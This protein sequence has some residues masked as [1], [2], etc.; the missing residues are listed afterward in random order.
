MG[1]PAELNDR[2]QGL[3]SLRSTL[4][5]L[6]LQGV[7]SDASVHGRIPADVAERLDHLASLRAQLS[8]L[9]AATAQQHPQAMPRIGRGSHVSR[10]VR[11]A[12]VEM[13]QDLRDLSRS[14]DARRTSMEGMRAQIAAL[15]ASEVD[16]DELAEQLAAAASAARHQ[17]RNGRMTNEAIAATDLALADV[18]RRG[19]V[20]G[21]T[22]YG[23]LLPQRRGDGPSGGERCLQLVR[24]QHT[25]AARP[26]ALANSSSAD[27]ERELAAARERMRRRGVLGGSDN[28]VPPAT[29]PA[30]DSMFT[31]LQ[32]LRDHG[33]VQASAMLSAAPPLEPHVLRSLRPQPL[34]RPVSDVCSVCLEPMRLGEAALSLECCHTF[35][36]RCLLPWLVRSACCPLCKTAVVLPPAP[37]TRHEPQTQCS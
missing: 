29:A 36:G 18:A 37:P 13:R 4:H 2:L 14:Y 25:T 19:G 16:A 24:S 1:T 15:R 3:A 28:S 35:H 6:P 22:A 5:E 10:A 30:R 17:L 34:V 32:Q 11:E 26:P 20:R 7:L 31:R 23:G 8:S 9:Q 21:M 12:A 27:R 33:L